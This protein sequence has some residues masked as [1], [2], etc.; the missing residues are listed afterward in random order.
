MAVVLIVVA[1]LF[2]VGG[3][4]EQNG[5]QSIVI[6]DK[7]IEIFE[8]NNLLGIVEINYNGTFVPNLVGV[9]SPNEK[10]VY[11]SWGRG[12]ASQGFIYD[13]ESGMS[14]E[15][16]QVSTIKEAKWTADNKFDFWWG[17][18]T[19][20]CKHLRSIDSNEPWIVEQIEN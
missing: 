12:D 9:L 4:N 18:V 16:G 15:L 11:Y 10:F 1:G 19:A 2:Y 3:V 17:C 5:E 6:K 14:Y 7:S 13:I 8:G 20:D